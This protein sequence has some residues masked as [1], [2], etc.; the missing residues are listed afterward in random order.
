MARSAKWCVIW[1]DLDPADCA[2][3][4]ALHKTVAITSLDLV[5]PRHSLIVDLTSVSLTSGVFVRVLL[6]SGGVIRV[7]YMCAQPFNNDL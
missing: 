1:V 5:T 6:S 2:G 4:Q 3:K 7:L